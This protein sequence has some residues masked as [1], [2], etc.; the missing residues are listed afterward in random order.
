[1]TPGGVVAESQFSIPSV[2]AI[3]PQV[4][5]TLISR[6]T[7]LRVRDG[8]EDDIE[9]AFQ[10]AL[11]N[12]VIHGN[13]QD[14]FKRVYVTLRCGA[15]GSVQITIQDEGAGFDV[16]SVPDPTTPENLVRQHG[17]GIFLMRAMM[18]EVSFDDGGRIVHMRKRVN[19]APRQ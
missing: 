4:V 2:V 8:S 5:D 14:P 12:A 1:M 3:V 17:R 6:V 11:L 13:R 18:D 16:A 19:V 10:E 15:D 7:S 9:L